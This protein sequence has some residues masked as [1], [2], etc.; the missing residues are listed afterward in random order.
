MSMT[1]RSYR[2]FKCCSQIRLIFSTASADFN[3]DPLTYKRKTYF[4]W[5]E[6]EPGCSNSPANPGFRFPAGLLFFGG[7]FMKGLP[8]LGQSTFRRSSPTN[9]R[10]LLDR[11]PMIFRTGGVSFLTRVGIATIWPPRDSC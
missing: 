8:E 4:A 3:V 10:T 1:F 9:A 6:W 2:F 7:F 11:S 5:R